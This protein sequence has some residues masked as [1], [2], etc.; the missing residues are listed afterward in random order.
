[1]A[2]YTVLVAAMGGNSTDGWVL[3]PDRSA[4]TARCG[5]VIEMDPA[6]AQPFLDLGAV[7][8]VPS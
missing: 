6:Q 1:M 5:D 7:R 3:F 2:A 8:A 4:T